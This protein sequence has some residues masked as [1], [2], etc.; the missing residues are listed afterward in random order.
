M[1]QIDLNCDMGEGMGND[2]LLMPFISSANISCGYHAGNANVIE[3]T[4][5]LAMKHNVAIGAHISFPDKENFGRAEMNFLP[6]KLTEI[7]NEQLFIIG[8]VTK[9]L[10]TELHHVKPHGAL[11]NM[12]A[13]NRSM[14]DTIAMA[15]K[16]YDDSLILYGLSGSFLITAAL[17]LGLKAASEVFA[18]R[19]YLEN[20]NLVPRTNPAALI[21]DP[22][23]VA[24]QVLT[25]LS[26]N[27][28][29]TLS[30]KTIPIVAQTI[31]LHGDG[32]QAVTFAAAIHRA[33][34]EKGFAI[35]AS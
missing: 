19:R 29:M 23:E 26:R 11:Y 6:E 31:C 35:S 13:V 3:E 28:V 30:G 2:H 15:V 20:G 10:G 34:I 16:K 7:I 4:I 22:V 27:E 9:R 1:H 18:D 5:R 8:Q 32:P 25:M 24:Q 33:L 12:A 21:R 17:E 14:A